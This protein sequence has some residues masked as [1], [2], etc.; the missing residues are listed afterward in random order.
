MSQR[1]IFCIFIPVWKSLTVKG[2][3]NWVIA[4]KQLTDA[5]TKRCYSTKVTSRSCKFPT[6]NL[7]FGFRAVTRWGCVITISEVRSVMMNGCNCAAGLERNQKGVLG[8]DLKGK[9]EVNLKALHGFIYRK[10]QFR[11]GGVTSRK[12]QMATTRLSWHKSAGKDRWSKMCKVLEQQPVCSRE[13][14]PSAT[15]AEKWCAE[16]KFWRIV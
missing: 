8:R 11:C 1:C 16:F 10:L 12:K 15:S 6:F 9:T 5:E 7:C 2:Q 4:F 3:W 14:E 13:R